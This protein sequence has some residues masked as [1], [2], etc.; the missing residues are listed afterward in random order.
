MHDTP[1]HTTIAPP[2]STQTVPILR[3]HLKDSNSPALSPGACR[4]DDNNKG[5]YAESWAKSFSTCHDICLYES[6]CTGAYSRAGPLGLP[7]LPV[8]G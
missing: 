4:T 5:N 1:P 6:A 8:L 7:L 2:C 3:L